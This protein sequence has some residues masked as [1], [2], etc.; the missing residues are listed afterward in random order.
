MTMSIGC[1]LYFIG[2]NTSPTP[3]G[4]TPG[5]LSKGINRHAANDSMLFGSTNFSEHN[6]HANNVIA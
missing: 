3:I 5:D 1:Y 4:Q 2:R 6:I